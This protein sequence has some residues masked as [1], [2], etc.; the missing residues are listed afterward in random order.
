[1]IMKKT[2][3]QS[4]ALALCMGLVSAPLLAEVTPAPEHPVN[5]TETA[6]ATTAME[7]QDNESSKKQD[8]RH[9]NAESAYRQWSQT[10]TEQ[11]GHIGN[12]FFQR[13]NAKQ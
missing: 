4:L 5:T 6:T 13:H 2:T 1:M 8:T 10:E 7:R 12:A 11:S 9:D 3:F